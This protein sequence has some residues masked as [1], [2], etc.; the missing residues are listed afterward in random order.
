M[1]ARGGEIDVTGSDS[2][3]FDNTLE[4]LVMNGMPFPLAVMVCIPE[5]WKHDDQMSEEKR[6]FYHSG[7]WQLSLRH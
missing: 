7:W 1:L 5:P 6:D 2:A 4:Y 3:M